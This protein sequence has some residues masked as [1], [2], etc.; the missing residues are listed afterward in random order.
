MAT[1][2]SMTTD[3]ASTS[4]PHGDRDV[5]RGTPVVPGI[6]IGPVIRPTATVDLSGAGGA[7]GVYAEPAVAGSAA[8]GSTAG[9]RPRSSQTFSTTWVGQGP[10][11][12]QTR[13]AAIGWDS[14]KA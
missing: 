7:M 1:R 12:S 9:T 8:N 4:T 10:R 11:G 3:A 13:S 2:S 14:K 5:R 6:A